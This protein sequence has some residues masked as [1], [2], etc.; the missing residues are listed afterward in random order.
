MIR[1][2]V[3]FLALLMGL[4]SSI[5][6]ANAQYPPPEGSLTSTGETSVDPGGTT[7]VTCTLVDD[8]GAPVGGEFV[9]FAITSDPGGSQLE[10]SSG[11]T[12]ANGEVTVELSAGTAPGEIEVTCHVPGTDLESTFVT[13]VLGAII[14]PP[15]TGD[16]GLVDGSSDSAFA[17]AAGGLLALIVA[18]GLTQRRPASLRQ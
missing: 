7:D 6:V 15:D 2:C 14:T 11:V 8:A 18:I 3:L 9:A 16:G 13:A 10:Q 5:A 1:Y 4:L 17:Y 12:D